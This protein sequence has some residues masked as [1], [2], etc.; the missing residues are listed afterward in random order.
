MRAVLDVNVIVAA[1]L[2]PVG[3][4][5][6]V[7]RGWRDG[8]FDLIASPKLLEELERTLG[9][10][11]ISDRVSEDEARELVELLRRDADICDDPTTAPS[12]RSADP[13]D[14]YLIALAAAENAALVSGDRHLLDLAEAL[15]IYRPAQFL[16]LLDNQR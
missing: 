14:D 13:A 2:S 8:A 3:S 9:Y 4:P 15:P 6:K 7:L 1:V 10:R 5:A 16:T 12:V 11:K